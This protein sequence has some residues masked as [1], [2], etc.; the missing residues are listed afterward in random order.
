MYTTLIITFSA[1]LINCVDFYQGHD[2]GARMTYA[3]VKKHGFI[4]V[5]R[6]K[7]VSYTYPLGTKIT[8]IACIDLTPNKTSS[9]NVINGGLNESYIDIEMVSGRGCGLKYIVEIYTS[10]MKPD[11]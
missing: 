4:F 1:I 10:K 6:S 5:E 3:E 11:S 9:I 8:G 7:T 2:F